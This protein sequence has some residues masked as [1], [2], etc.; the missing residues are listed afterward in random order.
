MNSFQDCENEDELR[1]GWNTGRNGG[2]G[3]NDI[4]FKN[5]LDIWE[6]AIFGE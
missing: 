2:F 1:I 5:W 6:L 3:R 4:F